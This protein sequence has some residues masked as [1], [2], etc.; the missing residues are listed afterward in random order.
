MATP[1]S[2]STSYASA[3][4]LANAHDINKIADYMTDSGVRGTPGDVLTDTRVAAALLRASGEVEMSCFRGGRYTPTDLADLTGASE[5]ALVG[6]VCDLAFYHLAKRR[7]PK[8]ENVPGYKEAMEK[9]QALSQGELIF[10]LQEAADAGV[11]STIDLSTD[12]QGRINQPTGIARRFFGKRMA[13]F[14]GDP[15]RGF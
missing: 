13:D 10:G 12:S 2:S 15:Y 14:S 9:L 11:M 1:I 4:Q 7:I 3:T 8:P 6:L 5:A